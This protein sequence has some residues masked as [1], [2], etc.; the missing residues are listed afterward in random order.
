MIA[1]SAGAAPL[2]IR[3]TAPTFNGRQSLKIEFPE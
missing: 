3:P 1:F 2:K